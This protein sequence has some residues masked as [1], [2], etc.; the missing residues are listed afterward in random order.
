MAFFYKNSL[1]GNSDSNDE[2]M[3]DLIPKK[4]RFKE[5]EDNLDKEMLVDGSPTPLTSWKDK[6][7]GQSSKSSDLGKN[8]EES[9]DI[10]L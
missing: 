6:L 5:K 4:V 2:G 9:N 10:D 1:C 3:V 8:G 7:L